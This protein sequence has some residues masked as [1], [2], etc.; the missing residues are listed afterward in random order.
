MHAGVVGGA[1]NEG[2]TAKFAA[3]LDSSLNVPMD[4]FYIKFDNVAPSD[5]G[6]YGATRAAAYS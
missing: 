6:L 5:L 1:V 4:R 3:L 2:I